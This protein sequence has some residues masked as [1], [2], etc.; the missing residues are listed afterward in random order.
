MQTTDVRRSRRTGPPAHEGGIRVKADPPPAGG[1]AVFPYPI[2]FR[3]TRFLVIDKPAGLP[4]HPGPRGGAS[5]EDA[6]ALLPRRKLGGPWLAHRLDADTAGC[7]L[8]A[9]RKQAL[10]AAQACFA[11]G[12]ARKTYW[13][14]VRGQPAS[15]HGHV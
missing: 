6:F 4:V 3:D 10:M 9:L 13:A 8:I 1:T 5:V 12:T 2:L 15:D 7:L 11:E 14:I